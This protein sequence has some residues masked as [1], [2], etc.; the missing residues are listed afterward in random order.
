LRGR[1][2]TTKL[3]GAGTNVTILKLLQGASID[4]VDG[5]HGPLSGLLK[6]KDLRRQFALIGLLLVGTLACAQPVPR[7]N[8]MT[9]TLSLVPSSFITPVKQPCAHPTEP[10]DID[11]YDGPL[12][13]VVARFSQR[14]ER[15]TVHIPRHKS[16]LRPCALSA[17]DK[18]HMFVEST[19]DPLSYVGA[20]WDAATA[21]IDRDD[22]SYL[23]GASGY[24]KRFGAAV[25]D[26]ATGDFFGIF[27]YPALFRQDPRYYRL[28]QGSAQSRLGHALAHRFVTQSDSGKLMPNYSE[29]FGTVSSKA[30]SN[31]YHPGNARGLGS[32]ASRVGYSV[33]NDMAWDVLREYWPE[34]ARKFKLPFRTP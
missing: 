10:F 5:S 4:K 33:A 1:L 25:T 24:G 18:F 19:A 30:L 12:S 11:D 7:V 16:D 9:P 13:H 34:I 29:W 26:N 22:P 32:T 6:M 8:N 23:M 27:L 2:L 28:G 31:L 21:Q 17:S 3:T 14:L 20:A 15:T